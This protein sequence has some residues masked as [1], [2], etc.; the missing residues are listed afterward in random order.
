MAASRRKLRKRLAYFVFALKAIG[1]WKYTDYTQRSITSS[2]SSAAWIRRFILRNGVQRQ[3]Y[4]P[5]LLAECG[6]MEGL[7]PDGGF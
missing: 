3:L 7:C 5:G 4:G 1:V 6:W 2:V